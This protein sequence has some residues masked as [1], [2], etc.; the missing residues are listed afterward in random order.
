MQLSEILAALLELA[1]EVDLDVRV[2]RGEEAHYTE[3]PPTSSCC[4]VKGKLWVML[5]PNDPVELHVR[6]L[7]EALRNEAAPVLEGR[8]LPPAVRAWID[9]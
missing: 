8:F 5:S 4:R 6:V 7:G 9:G 2:L 1:E 3:F